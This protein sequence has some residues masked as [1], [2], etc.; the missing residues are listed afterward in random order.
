MTQ[1][2]S[3][4]PAGFVPYSLCIPSPYSS[5]NF[6]SWLFEA[7]IFCCEVLPVWFWVSHFQQAPKPPVKSLV[8]VRKYSWAITKNSWKRK[9]PV[10]F[11]PQF[12]FFFFLLWIK[13][14]V[15][16][17][18]QKES[19]LLDAGTPCQPV[20]GFL[21]PPWQKIP[22]R[23]KGRNAVTRSHRYLLVPCKHPKML[24]QTFHP[25]PDSPRNTAC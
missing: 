18:N 21:E 9:V 1:W 17:E 13:T 8:L 14:G 24:L 23:M 6:Y 12:F 5:G 11:Q 16:K 19:S 25:S 7:N 4:P 20:P 2:I 22:S 10:M 3:V 15:E